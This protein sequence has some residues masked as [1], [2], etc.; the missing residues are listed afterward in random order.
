ML[1]RREVFERIGLF[2]AGFVFYYEDIDLCIRA[3]Q[4]GFSVALVP[5]AVIKHRSALGTQSASS[6]K[7]YQY[8]R[9]RILFFCKH[10]QG[11]NKLWFV[12]AQAPHL[13]T[14]AWRHT[15]QSRSP[16]AWWHTTRAIVGALAICWR[17]KIT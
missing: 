12:L 5:Q 15:R 2:D 8:E 10:L 14:A 9:N 16:T 4:A 6:F 13:F 1:V 11:M 17:K 7:I 3:R